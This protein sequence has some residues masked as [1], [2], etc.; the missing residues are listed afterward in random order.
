MNVCI[1]NVNKPRRP[2]SQEEDGAILRYIAKFRSEDGCGKILKIG[3][4]KLW[5]EMEKKVITNHSWQSM[6]DRYL[7]H[8]QHCPQKYQITMRMF[9]GECV[10]FLSTPETM[11]KKEMV[12]KEDKK[13][14]IKKEVTQGKRRRRKIRLGPIKS[15]F[16]SPLNTDHDSQVLN[17]SNTNKKHDGDQYVNIPRLE[18]IGNHSSH[19]C[20]GIVDINIFKKSE[21]LLRP[22]TTYSSQNT[23]VMKDMREFCKCYEKTDYNKSIKMLESVYNI[24]END[25]IWTSISNQFLIDDIAL[26]YGIS[27]EY[28]MQ[29]LTNH[30]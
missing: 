3:G 22:D 21:K 23:L 9:S 16:Y 24:S 2:Y 5:K 12:V 13:V 20:N 7:K 14:E 4:T 27:S 15:T 19:I 17:T 26:K 30:K 28:V 25:D 18:E 8:I 29:I 6:K 11:L 10:P 1:E